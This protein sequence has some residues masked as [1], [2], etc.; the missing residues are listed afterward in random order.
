MTKFKEMAC[1]FHSHLDFSLDGG[2]TAEAK[3]KHAAKIGRVADCVTDHGTMAGLVQ[4]WNSAKKLYKDKKIDKPIRSI[5]GLEAYI[6]DPHR[7]PKVQK[8]GHTSPQYMHVTIHFKTMKAY[9]YFCKLT[10]IMEQRAIVRWGERKPLMTFEEL[11]AISGEI[12][13]GSGCLVG[14]VQKNILNGR[15]D[16]A[17]ENY[18]RL[19]G[20]AGPGNFFVEVFPHIITHDWKRPE[21]SKDYAKTI[22]KAGEFTPITTLRDWDA[23]AVDPDPCTGGTIDIQRLPNLYVLEMARKYGDPVII[24]LDDHYAEQS[25]R[26]V[27]EARLGNGKEAWKFYGSYA[28]HDTAHCA[29]CFR[30]QLGTADSDIEAWVENSH[31]FVENFDKYKLE[32]AE[33]RWL[34]PTVEMVYNVKTDS[35][36]ILKELIE[37]HGRMPKPDHPQY[38]TYVDRVAYEISVLSDNGVA[39]FLPYFFVLEDAVSFAKAND[40]MWNTRGSAGGSLVLFL[41]GVSITDPIKYDLPFERF[42][43]LGRIKS[44]SLPDIDSDWEDRTIILDYILKKYGDRYSLIATNLLLHLK[45]SIKDV[46]RAVTGQV[47]PETDRM[48]SMIKG[49]PQGMSDAEWLFGYKDKTTGAM[50]KGFWDENSEGAHMLQQWAK[51]NPE[52]WQ[53]VQK[54][55]GICKTRGVHAG[56]IVITP[57]PVHHYAPIMQTNKGISVQYEMKAAEG[58]GLVKYDFLGV[59]TLKAL[60]KSLKSLKKIGINIPWGEFPYDPQVFEDV[61][62]KGDLAGIFQLNTKVVAPFVA[63]IKPRNIVQAAYLT[64]LCRPGALD[65]PCPDPNEAHPSAGGPTAADYYVLCAQGK[66]KPYFIHQD[67]SPILGETF[68]VIVTQEQTLRIF[69]DLADYNYETAEEVRRGIGKKDKDLLGRHMGALKEKCLSR[70]W[71][72]GQITT[73]IESIMASARYSFNMSHAVSYAIIAYNGC[74]LKKH[75]PLHFWKGEL[76]I[77]IDDHE[78]IQ[79]YLKE[80]GHLVDEVDIVKSHPSEWAIVDGRLVPPLSLIK[81]CGAASVLN[82]KNFIELP[83]EF[84]QPI[85][86]SD[87]EDHEE[88]IMT[89]PEIVNEVE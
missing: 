35:K 72:E 75:Y 5:H 39:D 64:S 79:E 73:L 63:R 71:S 25:D 3:I 11:E 47:W 29:E 40:I 4:H 56:G 69:R 13:L 37:K 76:D 2:S 78:T 34:L 74:Y 14:P 26:L 77:N 48:C 84:Y 87:P 57:G 45:S 10:P 50:V 41:I 32:T 7:P 89:T 24:S 68:G 49:A 62:L 82:I 83:L 55:I 54:C 66:R 70:G 80:C 58:V 33:D 59:T 17:K 9:Q 36:V 42:L 67:L 18:E 1:G 86:V 23:N 44:G 12:T 27:Q 81:G 16:W 51:D 31:R 46:E 88:A 65:A 22:I 21:V 61:I 38:Q 15:S 43:T 53:T 28:S 6:I 30:E 8:N 60:G 52:M 19:R 85:L 20:I